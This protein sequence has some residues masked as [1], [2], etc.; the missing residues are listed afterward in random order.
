[1]NPLE[2]IGVIAC[3]VAFIA[4]V[5]AAIKFASWITELAAEVRLNSTDLRDLRGNIQDRLRDH[6]IRMSA[7]EAS[8]KKQDADA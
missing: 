6:S 1:M 7:I 4:A 2:G 3:V 8:M 5:A